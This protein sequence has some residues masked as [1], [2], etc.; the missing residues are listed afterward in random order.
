[1]KPKHQ[2][3]LSQWGECVYDAQSWKGRRLLC[4]FTFIPIESETSLLK[5]VIREA[6]PMKPKLQYH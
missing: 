2:Y 3:H 5:M 6:F 1:M 4:E